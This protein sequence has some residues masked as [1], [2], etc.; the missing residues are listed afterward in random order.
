MSKK[1]DLVVKSGTYTSN[2]AEK[3]RWKTIGAVMDDGKGGMYAFI[4]ASFNPAGI[5]RKEG[6]ESIMVSF[7]EPKER[8]QSAPS[9]APEPTPEPEK[10]STEIPF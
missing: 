6:S 2:G 1:F 10:E 7:F 8:G 3:A 5:A 4:D 9:P